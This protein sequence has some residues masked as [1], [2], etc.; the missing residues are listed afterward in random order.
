MKLNNFIAI[1]PLICYMCG[2]D[3]SYRVNGGATHT[4]TVGDAIYNNGL[5]RQTFCMLFTAGSR[6]KAAYGE[7]GK[8]YAS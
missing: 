4:V 2:E 8:K 6:L 3:M 1:S 7:S 5:L